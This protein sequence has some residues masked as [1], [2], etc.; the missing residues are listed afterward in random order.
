V[1]RVKFIEGL[2]DAPYGD[3]ESADATFD[4]PEEHAV[5]LRAARESLVLLKND[6][7]TLPLSKQLKRILVCGPTA[8]MTKTS[9]DRYGSSG[10]GVITPLAGIQ[11][12]LQNTGTEVTFAPGCAATDK[13][14]PESELFP[15]PPAGAEAAGIKAAVAQAADADAVILCL[16]DSTDTIGEAKSRTSLDL[17][18]YQT[19]LARAL[20]KT[21]KPVIVVLL[22]GKPVSINWIDRYCPAVLEAWFP[23]EAGGT[24]IAEALFGDYNPGGKLPVTF[25]KTVGQIEF[26]FPFKPGSQA[27]Q[28]HHVDP[29]GFG[30]SMAE[31][32]LYPF[33]FGLSYT[34]FQFSNLK[35]A[36]AEIPTNGEVTVTYDIKNT[37]QRTGD[38]VAQLYF[39][40]QTSSVTTYELNLGGFERLTLQPG[41]QKTVTMKIPASA[42]RIINRTGERVVEPGQFTVRVGDSSVNLPLRGEFEVASATR[43]TEAEHQ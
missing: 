23:G 28:S 19:E 12:L 24:A 34:T 41:E 2:F 3:P 5:A 1:L 15:E 6:R 33:G 37:G 38:E 16:G 22:T 4:Q 43:E 14:W 29:N 20:V 21:G 11:N 32:P 17:P 10:A 36:P 31:G 9:L 35:I 7:Q 30:N 13:R 26:N 40:Q 39:H 27:P 25:P 18:G 8:K 42:L